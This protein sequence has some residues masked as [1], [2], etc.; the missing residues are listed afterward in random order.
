MIDFYK[1]KP[2]PG[3]EGLYSITRLGQ[4]KNDRFNRI[5]CTTVTRTGQEIVV[6]FKNGKR[7]TWTV[8]SLIRKTWNS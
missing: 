8:D 7:R 4:I 3:Y 1:Y 2:I 5:K 6:L